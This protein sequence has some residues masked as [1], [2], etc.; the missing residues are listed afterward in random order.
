MR[1]R[2]LGSTRLQVSEL[3]LGTWGLSGDGYGQVPDSEQDRVIDRCLAMGVTLFETADVYGAGAMEKKLGERLPSDGTVHVVTKIGTNRSASP[4]R[5]QFDRSYLTEAFDRSRERLRRDVVDVVLLHSPALATVEAGEAA[6]FMGELRSQ[7]KIGAW[8]V[9]AGSAEVARAAI[10]RGVDVIS[11][12]YNAL[13]SS[14]LR[15]LHD[16]V[17]RSGVGV[18]AH[19]ALHHGL[20]AGYW[21]LHKT[22]PPS[23]HRTERWTSD[24]LRRRVQHVSALRGLVGERVP[25]VRSAA[26][27]FVLSNDDVASVLLGPRNAIQLDMLVR[28][29][30]KEPPYLT[31]EQL[32]KLTFRLAQLGSSTIPIS[33]ALHLAIFIWRVAPAARGGARPTGVRAAGVRAR[34]A[35]VRAAGAR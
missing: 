11:I 25:N 15:S 26:L 19:S 23:D 3:A 16:D 28:D 2:P 18:L 10:T 27:R 20:L 5:K 7:G 1:K 35:G 8:G 34:A 9:S 21:S 22:F 24:D 14:D 31:P 32:D 33:R 6:H 13:F 12:T 30:G 29:A 4:P 17:S